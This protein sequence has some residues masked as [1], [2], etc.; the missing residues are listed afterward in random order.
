MN[1]ADN[2]PNVN[3]EFNSVDKRKQTVEDSGANTV[4]QSAKPDL[5]S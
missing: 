3:L 2:S 5:Y 4:E 1:L